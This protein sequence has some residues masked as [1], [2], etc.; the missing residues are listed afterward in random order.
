MSPTFLGADCL[1]VTSLGYYPSNLKTRQVTNKDT[2]TPTYLEV[3][4]WAYDV[5]DG[6][7]TRG[8]QAA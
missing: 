3:K 4:T 8:A 6:L 2:L 7:D 5:Q 1:Y